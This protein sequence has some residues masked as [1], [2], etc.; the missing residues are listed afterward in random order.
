MKEIY[1]T[2]I[3]LILYV[4]TCVPIAE[5]AGLSYLLAHFYL[6]YFFIVFK[7]NSSMIQKW[8]LK[9]LFERP[10]LLFRLSNARGTLITFNCDSKLPIFRNSLL[11]CFSFE[12]MVG[13]WAI[14]NVIKMFYWGSI[15]ASIQ[16]WSASFADQF[17]DQLHERVDLGWYFKL[18]KCK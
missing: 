1:N 15:S 5:I 17:A 3:N 2:T 16:C 18:L 11:C 7:R 12:V 6:Q 10:H 8:S 4:F 14:N 13:V 9:N